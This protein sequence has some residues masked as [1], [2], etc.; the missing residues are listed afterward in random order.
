MHSSHKLWIMISIFIVIIAFLL[1]MYFT[2][3]PDKVGAVIGKKK[4]G[5]MQKGKSGTVQGSAFYEEPP[6][7]SVAREQQPLTDELREVSPESIEE[8]KP[9]AMSGAGKENPSSDDKQA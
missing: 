8:E 6:A 5:Q 7:E 9:D 1:S 2:A 3:T 4:T